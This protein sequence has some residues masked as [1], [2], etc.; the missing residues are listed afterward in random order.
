MIDKNY[1]MFGVMNLVDIIMIAALI[2]FA[3]LALRF[4]A[5]R[6]AAAKPGDVP[7]RYTVEVQRRKPDFADKVKVGDAVE[8]SQRGYAIGTIKNV[9]AEPYLEDVPDYEGNIIRRAP[10][11]GLETVYIDIEAIGR[12]TDYTT[13]IG[14]FEVLVGK[15]VYI[16]TKRFAAGGYVVNLERGG[17]P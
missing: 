1:R 7:V 16:K 4:S 6:S 9:R 2:V 15:D 5:P 12:V 17:A 14:Y 11:D 8:D 13:L 3:V 10:V